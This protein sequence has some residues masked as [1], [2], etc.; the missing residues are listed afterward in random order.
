M[1]AWLWPPGS[2]E[3]W[4]LSYSPGQNLEMDQWKSRQYQIP[5]LIFTT[6][7][8]S[9]GY[10]IQWSWY[11]VCLVLFWLSV[12]FRWCRTRN[13]Q[14]RDLKVFLPARSA[15]DRREHDMAIWSA[16]IMIP[17]S[18]IR[19]NMYI[20]IQYNYILLQRIRCTVHD[21]MYT[22][23]YMFRCCFK[24][25]FSRVIRRCK[26]FVDFVCSNPISH[27][28]CLHLGKSLSLTTNLHLSFAAWFRCGDRA[29]HC[30]SGW[31]QYARACGSLRRQL[32]LKCWPVGSDNAHIW[33]SSST[34]ETTKEK[35]SAQADGSLVHSVP[36]PSNWGCR[37]SGAHVSWVNASRTI[38]L[39]TV[40]V[41]MWHA[42][43]CYIAVSCQFVTCDWDIHIF[44]RWQCSHVL[45]V[46]KTDPVGWGGQKF[47]ESP[48][49]GK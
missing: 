16:Q 9:W 48:L 18:H 19:S 36:H 43:S 7:K 20:N 46:R 29:G 39:K 22:Y 40:P 3:T 27:R 26:S 10:W 45:A 30:S 11:M 4:D 2:S 42:V 12:E 47:D 1:E 35:F 14:L 37:T 44:E 23:L 49:W 32:T 5:A 13:V 41:D 6:M 28:I 8:T 34:Q 21:Y 31:V 15:T 17:E 24:L 38:E 33:E 25:T